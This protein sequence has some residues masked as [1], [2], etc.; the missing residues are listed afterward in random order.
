MFLPDLSSEKSRNLHN[1]HF[2][3][4]WFHE[5]SITVKTMQQQDAM[6][7]KRWNLHTTRTYPERPGLISWVFVFTHFTV[8]AT[9]HSDG[10]YSVRLF[11]EEGMGFSLREAW[12]DLRIRVRPRWL[13][14]LAILQSLQSAIPSDLLHQAVS[15]G[16]SFGDLMENEDFS[17]WKAALKN[18]REKYLML[19]SD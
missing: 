14:Y 3:I 10:L 17:P 6:G 8:Y 9:R 15:Q 18:A 5:I 16:W 19:L 12:A 11:N 4:Y 13:S 1:T 7:I 2:D